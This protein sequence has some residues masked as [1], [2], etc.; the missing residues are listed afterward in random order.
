MCGIFGIYNHKEAQFLTYLGLYSLQHRGQEGAGIVSNLNDTMKRHRNLGLVNDVF[1]KSI[2]KSLSADSAIGHVRY[3]TSGNKKKGVD[4]VQ[5][6]IGNS[7]I[8]K[9]AIAHNGNLTNSH[10]IRNMLRNI[11]SVF[12]SSSDTE[13]ILHMIA[14][15]IKKDI[16]DALI[17]ALRNVEGAYSLLLFTKNKMIAARDPAGYRPLVLGT[18]NGAYIICSET[19][20][21]DAVNGEYVREILP[22][23]VITIDKSGFKSEFPFKKEQFRKCVFEHIY[24]ARPDSIIF[25]KSVYDMRMK[26]GIA[27]AKQDNVDADIVVGVPDSGTIAAIGYAQESGIPYM[28]GL[29][30]SRYVGRSFIQPDQESRDLVALLK[31]IPIRSVIE[32]KR[33]IV[34]DDS[35]VRGTTIKRLIKLFKKFNV[36]EIH[37]RSASPPVVGSC[38]YGIDTPNRENL[39]AAKYSIEEIRKLIGADSLAFL[40][41]DNLKNLQEKNNDTYCKSCFTSHYKCH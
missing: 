10:D 28:Q 30:R 38:Y 21:I 33:I 32:N 1:N 18:L 39:I 37:I 24:F 40:S 19:C 20:A 36:K 26:I 4:E 13:V 8:G 5:P 14:K 31:H 9:V 34:V 3:S 12:S 2:L 15:S 25:D 27:L 23:E 6:L 22:G 17:S 16:T 29:I 11:G 41:I 35:I 7:L